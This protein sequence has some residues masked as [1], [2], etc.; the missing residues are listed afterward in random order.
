MSESTASGFF[1]PWRVPDETADGTAG[2]DDA[3]NDDND[4]VVSSTSDSTMSATTSIPAAVPPI[5]DDNDH[6]SDRRAAG[7]VTT[8]RRGAGVARG[9]TRRGSESS[10]DDVATSTTTSLQGEDVLGGVGNDSRVS[11]P[12]RSVNGPTSVAPTLWRDDSGEFNGARDVSPL[13]YLSTLAFP[14]PEDFVV[15]INGGGVYATPIP[16]LAVTSTTVPELYSVRTYHHHSSV[17]SGIHR[18]V[19]QPNVYPGI[20]APGLC[21]RSVEEAVRMVHR[22]DAAAKQIKKMRPKKFRCQYC[23]M[24]FS[25]NGQ[26]KGHI[27][28]HTGKSKYLSRM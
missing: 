18:G 8:S 15:P 23:D 20:L 9:R 19:G 7:V 26:L 28:I 4:S 2:V 10:D 5:P 14:R 22:Q 16:D 27:R 25:N 11:L 12:R 13:E 24:A 6:L 3:G 17:Y 1:R 21:D